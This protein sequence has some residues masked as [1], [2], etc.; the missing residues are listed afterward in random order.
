MLNILAEIPLCFYVKF[1]FQQVD[2]HETHIDILVLIL[3][4][5]SQ[6]V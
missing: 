1:G 4:H 2:F 6:E 5:I 3:N